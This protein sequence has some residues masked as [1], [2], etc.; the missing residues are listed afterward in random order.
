[1][2]F[3][4]CDLLDDNAEKSIGVIP[5]MID[6]KYW[7]HFGGQTRFFGQVVTVKCFEDNSRIK[8]LF[9]TEGCGRVLVVDGGASLRCALLGDMIAQ[10][11][12][13]NGWAGIVISGCVRDVD[14]LIKMPLGVMAL[15]ATPQ[16]SVRKGVGDVG[17]N[18]NIGGVVIR[19]GAW[20]YADNNGILISPEPLTA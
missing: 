7:R 1:M 18:I 3:V 5:P 9:A 17:L 13:D 14:E 11:G 6:G 2:T 16:K 15:A 8:E 12:V 10:S 19:D 4:T 20:L